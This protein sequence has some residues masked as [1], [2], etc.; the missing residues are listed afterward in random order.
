MSKISVVYWS[1]TGNTEAMAMT[2]ASGVKAGGKEVEHPPEGL[3]MR[4]SF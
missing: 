4:R 2:V 1:G 3:Y